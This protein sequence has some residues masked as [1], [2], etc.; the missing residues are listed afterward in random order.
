M[1]MSLLMLESIIFTSVVD[2]AIFAGSRKNY[3]KLTVYYHSSVSAYGYTSNYDR[4]RAYWN[5]H[6]KVNITRA[7]ININRPDIYYIGNTSVKGLLDRV[8]PYN[9]SGIKVSASEYWDYTTVYMYDNQMRA[10]SNYSSSRINYNAA[11]EIGHTIKKAHVP[12]PYNSVMV[13]GW[14]TIPSSITSFD[15]SEVNR[16]GKY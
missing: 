9:S 5:A 14:Y 13:Q 11:H 10:Q 12:I 1:L 7:S 2:A 15:S 8:I 16:K 6:S 3:A 4:G